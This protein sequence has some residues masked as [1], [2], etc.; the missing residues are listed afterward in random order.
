[1]TSLRIFKSD[2]ISL[3][4]APVQPMS[5]EDTLFWKLRA[6]RKEKEQRQ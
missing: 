5:K 4:G 1:M 2:R 6:E 3:V